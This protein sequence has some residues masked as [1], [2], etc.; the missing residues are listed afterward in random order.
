[1]HSGSENQWGWSDM[2]TPTITVNEY[3]HTTI[4]YHN[5]LDHVLKKYQTQIADNI[6]SSTPLLDRLTQQ[7]EQPVST[8]TLI[9][10]ARKKMLEERIPHLIDHYET[11]IYALF[12]DG[13]PYAGSLITAEVKS[14]DDDKRYH[15]AW[16]YGGD[17]RWYRTYAKTRQTTDQLVDELVQLHLNAEE[18]EMK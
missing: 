11:Y 18:I 10:E 14:A 16:I 1:M 4:P 15:Y 3:E 17:N 9:A 7:E 6:F 2:A 8:E 13:V 5:T 12:D